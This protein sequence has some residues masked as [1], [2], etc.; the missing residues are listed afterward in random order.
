MGPGDVCASER[1]GVGRSVAV[2]V[3]VTVRVCCCELEFELTLL[4][5]MSGAGGGASGRA[6]LARLGGLTLAAYAAALP[7]LLLLEAEEAWSGDMM[8][9]D[10]E[11]EQATRTNRSRSLRESLLLLERSQDSRLKTGKTA[12]VPFAVCRLRMCMCVLSPLSLSKRALRTVTVTAYHL[13]HRSHH[14]PRTRP[15]PTPPIRSHT[16]V[17]LTTHEFTTLKEACSCT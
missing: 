3:A 12:R 4:N 10:Q 2:A 8:D 14:A 6:R 11:Q 1:E 13:S 7:L 9:K 15:P 16:H 5:D 17:R